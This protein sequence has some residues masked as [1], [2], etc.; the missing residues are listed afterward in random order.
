MT[1]GSGVVPVVDD[2]WGIALLLSRASSLGRHR[3]RTVANRLQ[4]LKARF[5]TNCSTACR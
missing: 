1:A 2:H 5:A 3:M 4:A